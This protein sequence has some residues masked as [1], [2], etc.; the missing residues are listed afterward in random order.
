VEGKTK[1]IYKVILRK[2]LVLLGFGTTFVF[3]ACYGPAPTHGGMVDV[4]EEF[5]VEGDSC[6][7][8]DEAGLQNDTA[9]VD[10]TDTSD[11]TQETGA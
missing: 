1:R 9:N 5:M 7:S 3:M 10:E 11:T 6:L 2:A 8:N 4:P